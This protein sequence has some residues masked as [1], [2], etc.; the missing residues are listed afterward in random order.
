VDGVNGE[1]FTNRSLI[2]LTATGVNEL[3]LPEILPAV[4]VDVHAYKVLVSDVV[5][6][7]FEELPVHIADV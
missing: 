2:E 3:E 4:T 5:S 1:L 7:M 6:W